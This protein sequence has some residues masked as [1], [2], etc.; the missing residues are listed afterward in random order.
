MPRYNIAK[1][2]P[3]SE[4]I[5]YPDRTHLNKTLLNAETANSIIG[6]NAASIVQEHYTA[7]G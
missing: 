6:G 1:R 5:Q 4:P 7:S 3:V 2:I